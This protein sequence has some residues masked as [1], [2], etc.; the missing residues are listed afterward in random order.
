MSMGS[1]TR[2]R[3]IV[4][5]IGYALLVIFAAVFLLPFAWYIST[6][7]KPSDEVYTIPIRWIPSHIAWDNFSRGFGILPFGLYFGNTLVIVAAVLVGTLLS[8]TLVAYGFARFKAKGSIVLFT[9]LLSTMMLPNQVTLIPTY[10]LFKNMGLLE[11]PLPLI[12]PSY[13]AT[14]AFYI[15]L[16]RQFFVTIPKE[17]EDAANIDG[18]GAL[19][20]LIQIFLPLC[21]PALTTVALF[22]IINTWND[23]MNQLIYLNSDQSYTIAVGLSFFNNK[24]GPQQ[25]N[26]LMA[27]SLATV[28]PLLILFFIGQRYFVEGI[29]TSGLKG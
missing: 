14:G 19:R 17:M 28:I 16:L 22:T 7:F 20:T 29:V 18:C 8:S 24:Y 25:V 26:L 27:V 23:F 4:N 2:N 6:A 13:F 1:K 5:G 3:L 11:T 10:I 12:I 15:F 21:K 9:V